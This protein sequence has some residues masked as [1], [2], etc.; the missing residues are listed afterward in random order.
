MNGVQAPAKNPRP[1]IDPDSSNWNY[2]M[3]FDFPLPPKR[4]KLV[5]SSKEFGQANLN[6]A[7][8]PNP[9]P[10][11]LGTWNPGPYNAVTRLPTQTK[12]W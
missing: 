3:N 7:V 10:L 4:P 1:S 9:R 2:R 11:N 8:Q 12:Y 6:Q 5:S